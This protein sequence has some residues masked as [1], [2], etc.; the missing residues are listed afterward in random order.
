MKANIWSISSTHQEHVQTY[1][2]KLEFAPIRETYREMLGFCFSEMW[3]VDVYVDFED[4]SGYEP[5]GC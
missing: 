2:S 5:E 3:G 4:E 1:R